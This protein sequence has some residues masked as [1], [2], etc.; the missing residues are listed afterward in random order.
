[1]LSSQTWIRAISSSS[2][3]SDPSLELKTVQKPRNPGF[4]FADS[5]MASSAHSPRP[6]RSTETPTLPRSMKS[7]SR[8][9]AATMMS[10]PYSTARSC[11]PAAL[12]PSSISTASYVSTEVSSDLHYRQ[13]RHPCLSHPISLLTHTQVSLAAGRPPVGR[14]PAGRPPAGRGP[15]CDQPVTSLCTR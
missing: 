9:G 13:Q 7:T 6:L 5:C 8:P 2:E 12:S 3:N 15:A 11:P 4:R 14:P 10:A 1:M